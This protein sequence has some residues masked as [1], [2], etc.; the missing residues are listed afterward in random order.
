M[1]VYEE[2]EGIIQRV[3]GNVFD[4]L[5]FDSSES[6]DGAVNGTLKVQFL[7]IYGDDIRDLLDPAEPLPFDFLSDSCCALC[8][9]LCCCLNKA[10]V[11][12]TLASNYVVNEEIFRP[13]GALVRN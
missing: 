11:A 7:E 6:S 3:A 8:N 10:S 12:A 5:N 4:R 1:H 13:P 2:E 9:D